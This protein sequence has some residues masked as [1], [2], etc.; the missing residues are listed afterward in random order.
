MSDVVNE[1]LGCRPPEKIANGFY[2]PVKIVYRVNDVV[3]YGCEIGF[4]Y[5]GKVRL[6]CSPK[7]RWNRNPPECR[8]R[9]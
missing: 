7:G 3:R 5:I 1:F 6:R 4:K 8:R 2:T 9:E